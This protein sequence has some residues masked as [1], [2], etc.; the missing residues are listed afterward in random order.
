M[1]K[2]KEKDNSSLGEELGGI[3]GGN[4]IY[5]LNLII[6]EVNIYI[7]LNA[8]KKKS[9]CWNKSIF[10][11][12]KENFFLN[13][14]IFPD[15]KNKHKLFLCW[16]HLISS[17]NDCPMQIYWGNGGKK[18]SDNFC[19]KIEHLIFELMWVRR[20]VKVSESMKECGDFPVRHSLYNTRE[21]QSVCRTFFP[22]GRMLRANLW[23]K[24]SSAM[25]WCLY[26]HL[27]SLFYAQTLLSLVFLWTEGEGWTESKILF[28]KKMELHGNRPDSLAKC[29][30]SVIAGF[31]NSTLHISELSLWKENTF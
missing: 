17:G 9:H 21:I 24:C 15:L 28:T 3:K 20:S 19:L 18:M 1:G 31:M 16:L 25:Q 30:S 5:I 11:A 12:V 4:Y 2:I 8:K 26:F 14:G 23:G 7:R 10:S 22:S 29:T 6:W 13:A 27:D